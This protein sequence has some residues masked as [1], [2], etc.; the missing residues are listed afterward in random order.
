MKLVEQ[1]SYNSI[2]KLGEKFNFFEK[3]GK[4]VISVENLEFL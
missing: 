4:T 3:K 1:P 2:V